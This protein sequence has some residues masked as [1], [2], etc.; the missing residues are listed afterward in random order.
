MGKT[1]QKEMGKEEA[2]EWALFFRQN[3]EKRK[4]F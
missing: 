3:R 4:W 1:K 2:V